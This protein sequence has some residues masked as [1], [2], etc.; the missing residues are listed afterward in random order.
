M[1]RQLAWPWLC[2]C[3][4]PG[5]G[6]GDTP[7]LLQDE[8]DAEIR[9]INTTNLH[10]PLIARLHSLSLISLQPYLPT[11][12]HPYIPA[13]LT[14]LVSLLLL[15]TILLIFLGG[16]DTSVERD[17]G[18][19]RIGFLG[20]TCIS[21]SVALAAGRN[22]ILDM[23][24]G[25]PFESALIWH[26]WIG[27]SGIALIAMHGGLYLKSWSHY[28][29]FHEK[30]MINRPHIFNGLIAF[31]LLCLLFLLS[32]PII[33]RRLFAFF[34][35]S[36]LILF[37]LILVFVFLH[38]N[39]AFGF[40]IAP[41]CFYGLDRM[42][43]FIRARRPARIIEA[44]ILNDKNPVPS[45]PNFDSNDT[46]TAFIQ[47]LSSAKD[48]GVRL[49][50]CA[51]PLCR[52]FS[53][54]NCNSMRSP[55]FSPGQYIFLNVPEIQ[56]LSWHPFS[57]ASAPPVSPA[58]ADILHR[59]IINRN[60]F[61][62]PHPDYTDKEFVKTRI[63]RLLVAPQGCGVTVMVKSLGGFTEKLKKS[64]LIRSHSLTLEGED[65]DEDEEDEEILKF[66]DIRVEGPYGRPTFSARE[67][68]GF[69]G[70]AGGVGITP[71]LSF[72]G[73]AIGMSLDR[74]PTSS[75][76]THDIITSASLI[77]NIRDPETWGSGG[78]WRKW[79][80][81]NGEGMREG[82]EEASKA[83]EWSVR[84]GE[85]GRGETDKSNRRGGFEVRR[86]RGGRDVVEDVLER[87]RS[88]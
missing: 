51:P 25:I 76:H 71:L 9:E 57:L 78:F 15:F 34:Y 6:L 55:S 74:L 24:F 62:P 1:A 61:G 58:S 38:T 13:T 65:S 49:H 10:S 28:G 2:V 19:T 77:W 70:V 36:H 67:F 18:Y 31:I 14:S 4:D 37:P 5:A 32:L 56:P 33:R 17:T 41:L 42:V 81:G 54:N 53:I 29:K 30:N 72:I 73:D 20:L 82:E 69:V 39:H 23:V 26:R 84:G 40:T 75:C 7:T 87:R 59:S 52:H 47:S 21:L 27:T 79:E 80:G 12:L 86:G 50:I 3:R 66:P 44:T 83:L 35:I 63:R 43:R 68:G 45:S 85:W 46:D 48:G 88:K 11:Y 22:S 64:V 60:V 8:N 16:I